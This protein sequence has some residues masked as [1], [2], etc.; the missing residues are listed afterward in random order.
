M[1]KSFIITAPFHYW[2]RSHSLS[3]D[4]LQC[5]LCL[6]LLLLFGLSAMK[7]VTCCMCATVILNYLYVVLAHI[8]FTL[9]F[10]YF[11]LFISFHRRQCTFRSNYVWDLLFH[12]RKLQQGRKLANLLLFDSA[13]VVFCQNSF[14]SYQIVQDNFSNAF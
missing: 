5:S 9:Y 11:V 4:E 13:V 3:P 6:S 12:Y 1:T 8:A 10:V 2:N 7:Y 14:K